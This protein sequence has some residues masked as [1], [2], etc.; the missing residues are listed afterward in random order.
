MKYVSPEYKN[1]VLNVS[2]VIAFSPNDI[3]HSSGTAADLGLS[4]ALFEGDSA[5]KVYTKGQSHVD[6]NDLF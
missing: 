2:D 4:G 3:A 5:D 1:E 6:V